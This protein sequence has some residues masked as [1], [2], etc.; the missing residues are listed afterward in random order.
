MIKIPKK[1]LNIVINGNYAGQINGR[2]MFYI[3]FQIS[4]VLS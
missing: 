4:E 3:I 1:N 2:V